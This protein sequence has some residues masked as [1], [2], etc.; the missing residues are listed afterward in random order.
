MNRLP[1]ARSI[2]FKDQGKKISGGMAQNPFCHVAA[3]GIPRAQNKN[4]SFHKKSPANA[5]TRAGE[6]SFHG[7]S[8]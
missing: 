7:I 4:F 2:R 3:T 1:V 8:H 6:N 5:S